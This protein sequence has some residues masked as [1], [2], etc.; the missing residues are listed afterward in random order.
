MGKRRMPEPR[1]LDS[2]SPP[3]T[4][5]PAFSA[6]IQA[7]AARVQEMHNSITG[8]TFDALGM[9]PGLSVQARL[10]QGAHDAI[11]TGVYAAVRH[12][13][14]AL[15]SLAGDAER[16]LIDPTRETITGP[17]HRPLV[18]QMGFHAQ[19]N[20]LPLARS[21]LAHLSKRVCVFV[22]GLACDERS[23]LLHPDVWRGSAW[24]G[25]GASYGALLASELG[26]SSLYLRYNTALAVDDNAAQLATQLT[27]L[28]ESAPQLREIAFIGHSMGG[29]VARR[30]CELG[31]EQG[32]AWRDQVQTVISLG[33]PQHTVPLAELSQRRVRGKRRRPSALALRLVTGSVA[34]A[35]D[36]FMGAMVGTVLGDGIVLTPTGFGEGLAGDVQSVELAE[37]GH[38]SLLN[39][40]RVYGLIRAW[41]GAPAA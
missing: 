29:L 12:G 25:E 24:D 4:Y 31:A 1:T 36:A 18:V 37:L 40:P 15:F 17:A 23:W 6:G 14:G 21:D 34:D 7:T 32:L 41:L 19:G 5:T 38:M 8:K 13:T 26:I 30:A 35:S 33:S 27:Q 39:H 28:F 3:A 22:H 10:A 2:A 11:T 9:W 20:P 16:F